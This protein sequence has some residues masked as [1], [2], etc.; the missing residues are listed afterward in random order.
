MKAALKG[1]I[2]WNDLPEPALI[3]GAG[4]LFGTVREGV[5]LFPRERKISV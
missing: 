5:I 4:R 2:Q 1:V 3:S